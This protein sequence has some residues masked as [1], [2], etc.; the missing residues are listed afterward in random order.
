MYPWKKGI[1]LSF[2]DEEPRETWEDCRKILQKVRDC[3]FDCVE[4]SFSHDDYFQKYH[5]TQGETARELGVYCCSLGLLPWSIHLPF[6]EQWDLS[7]DDATEAL[8]DDIRLI[9]AA[10]RAGIS[11]AV[12]HPSYEPVAAKDRSRRI[13][14][15]VRNLKTLV[16]AAQENGLILGL[17][18]LPR[19]CL[20]NTSGEMADLLDA[21][22]AAFVFDTNHSLSEDNVLFLKN[23]LGRGYCPVSLHLSDY[24]RVDE[25]HD[26]P[27]RGVNP[28]H[29]LLNLLQ[30]AG[31]RGPALYEIRHTVSPGHTVTLA[32]LTTNI[33]ALLNGEIS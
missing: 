30:A 18:N 19:T 17:E 7:R 20:G 21:T 12:I 3:G 11:V 2:F 14:N 24:D 10:Q 23:L 6:S 22:G 16:A 15:V 26:L 32:E 31:Y 27:G 28:W 33:N 25:R 5:F 13:A 1:S 9:E 29:T 4:L 8:R